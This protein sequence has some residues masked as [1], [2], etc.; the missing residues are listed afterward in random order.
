MN[1][2]AVPSESEI[3]A[4][5]LEGIESYGKRVGVAPSG[6]CLAVMGDT[7]FYSK[8]KGGA[9]FTVESYQRFLD[10]FAKYPDATHTQRKPRIRRRRKNGSG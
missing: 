2:P 4:A 3:R 10:Y 5:L 7:T 1:T 6:V 9:N 8:I